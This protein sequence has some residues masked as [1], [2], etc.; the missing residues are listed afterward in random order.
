MILVNRIFTYFINIA[1]CSRL[2]LLFLSPS[3]YL[4]RISSV[5]AYQHEQPS[6][7]HYIDLSWPALTPPVYRSVEVL[8]CRDLG[9]RTI[10]LLE[11]NRSSFV[12][13]T[14][15]TRKDSLL[16]TKATVQHGIAN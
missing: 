9:N 14:N 8:L 12:V 16:S 15:A 3:S 7:Y 4:P 13:T 1:P 6:E 5:V 10:R 2:V 11:D